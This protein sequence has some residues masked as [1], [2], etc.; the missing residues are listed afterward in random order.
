VQRQVKRKVPTPQNARAQSVSYQQ[1][2]SPPLTWAR[3]YP[4]SPDARVSNRGVQVP[5]PDKSFSFVLTVT[6]ALYPYPT[7]P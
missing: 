1:P 7:Y 2:V 4:H 6:E 5:L 3:A